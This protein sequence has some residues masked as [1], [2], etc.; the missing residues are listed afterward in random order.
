M[1]IRS[2]LQTEWTVFFVFTAGSVLV[3]FLA[4][5]LIQMNYEN[6]IPKSKVSVRS[7][8]A[9]IVELIGRLWRLALY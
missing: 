4:Y 6:G 2:S 3:P 7:L 8:C 1:K 5:A 9:S